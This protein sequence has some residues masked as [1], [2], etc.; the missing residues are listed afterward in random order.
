MVESQPSTLLVASSNLVPRSKLLLKH[1]FHFAHFCAI[2]EIVKG[3]EFLRK[4]KRLAV[5]RDLHFQYEPGMG[6]DACGLRRLSRP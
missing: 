2:L 4:L 1:R 5:S 6:K 3:S